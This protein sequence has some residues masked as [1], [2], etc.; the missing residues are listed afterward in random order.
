M[1]DIFRAGLVKLLG[2]DAELLLSGL[3]FT[4]VGVRDHFFDLRFH[5][6]FDRLVAFL[7]SL[8]LPESFTGTS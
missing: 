6:R 5:C 3:D 7:A 8:A 2:G 4:S 1:N